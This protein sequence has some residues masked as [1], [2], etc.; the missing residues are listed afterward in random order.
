MALPGKL[1][2]A[3]RRVG[4]QL[5]DHHDDTERALEPSRS[6]QRFGLIT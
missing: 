6:E 5:R 2:F 1:A 4:A 3:G